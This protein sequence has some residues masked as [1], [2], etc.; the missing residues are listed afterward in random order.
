MS[1]MLIYRTF[2]RLTRLG[3]H[4]HSFAGY[5]FGF[6][7]KSVRANRIKVDFCVPK[8][9]KQNAK[10]SSLLLP[11]SHLHPQSH[12]RLSKANFCSFFCFSLAFYYSTLSSFVPFCLTPID[13]FSIM[14]PAAVSEDPLDVFEPLVNGLS[15]ISLVASSADL[16]YSTVQFYEALG[17]QAVSLVRYRKAILAMLMVVWSCQTRHSRSRW[18]PLSRL[19]ER[20]L[21][22]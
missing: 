8:R 12:L 10:R 7:R 21:V 17:F 3:L 18:R 22:T 9:D 6:G 16:F 15:H 20:N 11:T 13:Q 14:A 1:E 4:D 19:W 2:V 5:N